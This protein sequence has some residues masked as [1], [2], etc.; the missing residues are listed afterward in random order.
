VRDLRPAVG[1]VNRSLPPLVATG[2]DA[3]YIVNEL[4]YNPPGS[5]E[6]FLFW[7]SWFFHNADSILSI[8]DAHGVAWRGLVVVGCSS[9]ATATTASPLLAPLKDAGVCPKVGK[10]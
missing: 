9:L 1:D 2:K 7:T 5:E 8:E 4:L 6:G 10:Q 3:N